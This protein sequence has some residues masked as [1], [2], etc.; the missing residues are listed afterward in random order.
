MSIQLSEALDRD[1]ATL[2]CNDRPEGWRDADFGDLL[3]YVHPD[4]P[5]ILGEIE[6]GF[7]HVLED[8]PVVGLV[9]RPS[10]SRSWDFRPFG[11]SI[12]VRKRR[13]MRSYLRSNAWKIEAG[14]MTRKAAKKAARRFAER[15]VADDPAKGCRCAVRMGSRTWLA[16]L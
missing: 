15:A 10:E 14:L 5:E 6:P 8:V 7:E 16:I 3:A 13:V 1:L 9:V 4:C 2:A 12:V 11:Q